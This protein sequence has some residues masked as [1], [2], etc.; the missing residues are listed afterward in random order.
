MMIN[1][2]FFREATPHMKLKMVYWKVRDTSHR[3]KN[4]SINTSNPVTLY[5]IKSIRFWTLAATIAT[6][7]IMTCKTTVPA[8]KRKKLWFREAKGHSN[9]C[10]T[11]QRYKQANL[12]NKNSSDKTPKL[13]TKLHASQHRC[14]LRPTR[15]EDLNFPVALLKTVTATA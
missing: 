6:V 8:V 2:M 12:L 9:A 13:K 14:S 15:N 1:A 4:R 10:P 7:V 11:S 3:D 5:Q